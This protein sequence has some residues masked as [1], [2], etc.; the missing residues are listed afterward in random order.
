MV[1]IQRDCREWAEEIANGFRPDLIIFIAKSGYLFA[2]PMSQYFHCSMADIVAKRPASAEKDKLRRIIRLIPEK[3]ILRTISSALMYKFNEKKQERFVETS[4]RY[5][6]EKKKKHDRILIVD[7][8]VDTGWTL[9]QVRKEVENSFPAAIVRTAGYSVIEYS[10]NRIS[11]DYYRYKNTVILTATSRRSAE[12]DKFISAYE[13]WL[14][15][16]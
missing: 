6:C 4:I 3:I 13:K 12:Y 15:K 2:E 10:K 14:L 8:S 11:V 9:L 1:D 16:C 5:N 7:D